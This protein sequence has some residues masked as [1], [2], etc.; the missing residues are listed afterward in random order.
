[1]KFAFLLFTALTLNS[2]VASDVLELSNTELIK[3]HNGGEVGLRDFV[4]AIS[5]PSA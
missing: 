4:L 2:A 1:M 5:H 3:L